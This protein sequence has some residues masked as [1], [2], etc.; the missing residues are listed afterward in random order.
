[1]Y[2]MQS[3]FVTVQKANLMNCSG[4]CVEMYALSF[5]RNTPLTF[6]NTSSSGMRS[7][8]YGGKYVHEPS[9]NSSDDFLYSSYMMNTGVVHDDC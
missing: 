6:A 4:E 1:M 5:C 2:P 7:G 8:L 9:S 3:F